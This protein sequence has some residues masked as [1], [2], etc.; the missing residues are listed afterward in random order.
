MAD[1]LPLRIGVLALQGSFSEHMALLRRIPGI[2]P[3]EVKTKEQLNS[4]AGLII[5]GACH[6]PT[7]FSPSTP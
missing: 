5:P 1:A 3:V 2:D 6:P 7:T 4:V